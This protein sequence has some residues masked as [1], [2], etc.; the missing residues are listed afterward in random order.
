MRRRL[1]RRPAQ[2]SPPAERWTTTTFYACMFDGNG[3]KWRTAFLGNCSVAGYLSHSE[4]DFGLCRKLRPSI[5]G[6]VP[7]S[8]DCSGAPALCVRSG[9]RCAAPRRT[10]PGQSPRPSRWA[11]RFTSGAIRPP[12]MIGSVRLGAR[13]RS[14]GSPVLKGCHELTVLLVITLAAYADKNGRCYP[15][16]PTLAA[17]LAVTRCSPGMEGV[18]QVGSREH[19]TQNSP[20]QQLEHLPSS[21]DPSCRLAVFVA[22]C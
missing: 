16:V 9:T 6:T 8:T 5:L 17:D 13:C 11:A 21:K 1:P 15:S 19:C 20:L 14:G 12:M 22:V 3:E 4:A 18:G 10:A 2:K 7:K